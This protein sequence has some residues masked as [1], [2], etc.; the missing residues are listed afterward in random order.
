MARGKEGLFRSRYQ[1]SGDL[2][3]RTYRPSVYDINKASILRRFAA[4]LIDMILLVVLATGLATLISK[5][6]DYDGNYARLEE[7]YLEHGIYSLNPDASGE[8]DKYIACV[9]E[10]DENGKP[11]SNDACYLS[12]QDFY[13]DAEAVKYSGICDNLMIVMLSMSSLV[14]LLILEFAVPLILKKGKTVGKLIMHI[15][16]L[17]TDRVKIRSWQLFARV[18]IGRFAIETMIPIFCIVFAFINPRGGLLGVI[19]IAVLATVECLCVG[20]TKNSQALHDIVGSTV[21]V[22]SDS[23]FFANSKEELE[24][25]LAEDSKS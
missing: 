8:E 25:R 13:A 22:D 11:L 17:G 21:V 19:V 20:F 14:G 23:Q 24:Q 2:M 7:K 4:F 9:V 5:I 3:N 6:V 1:K 15:G 12:W 10:Y 16:L 18:V